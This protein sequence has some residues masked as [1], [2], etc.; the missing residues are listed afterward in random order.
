MKKSFFCPYVQNINNS[1]T[2]VRYKK[3]FFVHIC[4]QHFVKESYFKITLKK[5]FFA[6]ISENM[7]ISRKTKLF[8]NHRK[9]CYFEITW[10]SLLK[11][12][13]HPKTSTFQEKHREKLIFFGITLKNRF[14]PYIRKHKHFEKSDPLFRSLLK[15]SRKIMLFWDHFEK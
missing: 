3:S 10:S 15:I 9:L 8:R 5:S 6:H 7:N 4:D 2:L 12:P 14:Y 1:R 13:L 11:N